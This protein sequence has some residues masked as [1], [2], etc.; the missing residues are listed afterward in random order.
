MCDL[1][2]KL[3]NDGK[4]PS[5]AT[6]GSA[7]LD[8]YANNDEDIIIKPG[9]VKLVSTGVCVK[10]NKQFV[11]DVRSRSGLSAK[12]NIFILNSPGTIDSDYRGEIKCILAN[13]GK[14][15]FIV[16]RY[17]R[18]AQMVMLKCYYPDI[19]IKNDLSLDKDRN[20]NGFGSTGIY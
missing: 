14:E 18:I 5:R 1:E 2:I 7:G 17:M 12:N 20:N 16:K 3:I 13:F 19:I 15:D 11:I 8:L 10:F 4:L 6:D 9:E